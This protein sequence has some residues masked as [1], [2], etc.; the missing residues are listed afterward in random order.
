MARW[1]ETHQDIVHLV[2]VSQQI[3][4]GGII[5]ISLTDNTK[6]EG[7]IRRMNQGNNAGRGGW[8]YYGELEIETRK[9]QRW[10]VDYLDIGQIK[11]LW[12][13]KKVKEYEAL[14]LITISGE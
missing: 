4:P 1:T 5:E 13:N 3:P 6:I 11:N 2:E 14:G 7:V 12:S 9:H 10:V 8:K